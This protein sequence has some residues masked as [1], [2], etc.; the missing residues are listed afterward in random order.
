MLSQ[1]FN[2]KIAL[3][4]AST[5]GIGRETA[6][7]LAESGAEIVAL[8]GRNAEVGAQVRDELAVRFPRTE[9]LFLQADLNVPEQQEAMFDEIERRIGRIDILVHCGGAQVRPE[10]FTRIDPATYREQIDG[11]FTSFV[12]CCRRAIPMMASGGSIVAIASDAGKIATPAESIIGAMKAAVIMF[13][14]TLALEVSRQGIRVNVLTPSL[15]ANTK[16]Y[17]RIMSGE[18]SRKIFEKASAKAK[19]GVPVPEDV[20]PMAVFLSSPFGSKIT[21]Q[22]ISVN[23]GISAA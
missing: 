3:V 10:F 15:V 11:H 2:S 20:A 19:L 16:S 12:T 1:M 9:F 14:R 17:D 18:A 7:L 4:T 6:R 8:N 23:G 5:S 13:V 21:G 22:A